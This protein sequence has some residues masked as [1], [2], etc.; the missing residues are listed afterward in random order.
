M[1][2]RVFTVGERVLYNGEIWKIVWIS[3]NGRMVDLVHEVTGYLQKRVYTT[4]LE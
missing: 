3:D 1:L 2:D 4:D